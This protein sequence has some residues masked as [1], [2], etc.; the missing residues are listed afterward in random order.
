ML[1]EDRKDSLLRASFLWGTLISPLPGFCIAQKVGAKRLFGAGVLAA[2]AL[3]LFV[4][5]AWG[6]VAHVILR[7]VQG[8]ATV[9]ISKISLSLISLISIIFY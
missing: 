4:P 1:E 9:R 5:A 3:S 6:S 8:A 2:G 7:A